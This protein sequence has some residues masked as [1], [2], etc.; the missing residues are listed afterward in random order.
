MCLSSSS[1]VPLHALCDAMLKA[2]GDLEER[3]S[4]RR[5]NLPEPI[6]GL[7]P[8]RH[9]HQYWSRLDRAEGELDVGYDSCGKPVRVEYHWIRYLSRAN[10]GDEDVYTAEIWVRQNDGDWLYLV[11]PGRNHFVRVPHEPLRELLAESLN[12]DLGT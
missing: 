7:R 1:G 8:V 5:V 11:Q 4:A 2:K 12:I 9:E 10:P 6:T 3:W